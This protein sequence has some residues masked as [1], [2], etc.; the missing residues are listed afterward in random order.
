[1]HLR[2]ATHT[3]VPV[4][5]LSA[6]TLTQVLSTLGCYHDRVVVKQRVPHS[7]ENAHP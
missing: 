2:E 6:Q 4:G 3:L 5:A 1:M 7:I